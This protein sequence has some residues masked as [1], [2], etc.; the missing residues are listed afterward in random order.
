MENCIIV[1][2]LGFNS[3]VNYLNLN[4]SHYSSDFQPW[5]QDPMRGRLELKW[6]RLECLLIDIKKDRLN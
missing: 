5:G 2:Q 4:I 3:Y 1:L 6:G